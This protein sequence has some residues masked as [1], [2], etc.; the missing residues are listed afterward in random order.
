MLFLENLSSVD[1]KHDGV[2]IK[3]LQRI[4]QSDR[5]IIHDDHKRASWRLLRGEF[6]RSA[7]E[8]RQRHPGRIEP[9]RRADVILAV[10]D[11]TISKGLLYAFLPTQS[12][13]GLTFHI[14]ADFFPSSDRKRIIFES[15]FQSEWNRAAIGA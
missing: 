14:N 4:V 5:V 15:D 7:D 12:E 13:S 11:A 2:V 3:R 9:K 8:L 10:P 1:L 6:H